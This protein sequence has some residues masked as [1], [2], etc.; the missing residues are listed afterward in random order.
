MGSPA[1]ADCENADGRVLRDTVVAMRS[2]VGLYAGPFK[3]PSSFVG[4]VS[5]G[6]KVLVLLEL[7]EWALVKGV[8]EVNNGRY[9]IN[10]LEGNL[11]AHMGFVAKEDLCG[12]PLEVKKNIVY[13][14][15]GNGR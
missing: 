10:I 1:L 3:A 15:Y 4:S 6:Q 9:G 5:Q 7:E 12:Q 8:D 11:S 13:R 2:D 14:I